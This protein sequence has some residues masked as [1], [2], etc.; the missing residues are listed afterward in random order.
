MST[1]INQRPDDEDEFTDV[2]GEDVDRVE[3]IDD[4]EPYDDF[5]EYKDEKERWDEEH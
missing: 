3:Y 4:P 5:G 1:K 2:Y